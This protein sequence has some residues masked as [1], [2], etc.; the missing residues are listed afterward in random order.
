M[1]YPLLLHHHHL[2]T[3]SLLKKRQTYEERER[4]GIRNRGM[5][6]GVKSLGGGGYKAGVK[7]KRKSKCQVNKSD[8][9]TGR[10]DSSDSSIL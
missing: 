4:G 8:A 6:E 7:R 3:H 5:L 2:L 9:V 1:G 10:K